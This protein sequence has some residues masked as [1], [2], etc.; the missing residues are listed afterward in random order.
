ME[1]H[2]QESLPRVDMEHL[3]EQLGSP[4]EKRA[5]EMDALAAT[6]PALSFTL[7][8]GGGS[9]SKVRIA[10]EH[11]GKEEV[12]LVNLYRIDLELLFSTSPFQC[13]G[14]E[15]ATDAS[16]AAVA[17]SDAATPPFLFLHSNHTIRLPLQQQQQP[18]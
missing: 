7:L 8:G 9:G 3:A 6:E 12:L 15:G 16:A 14:A 10:H 17:A 4:V 18:Q 5:Q 1:Q 11:L 2:L 13:S